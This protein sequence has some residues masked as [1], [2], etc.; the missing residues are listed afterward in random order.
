MPVQSVNGACKSMGIHSTA[1]CGIS[2]KIGIL[3][4]ALLASTALVAA[5]LPASAQDATWLASPGSGD[6]A[7]AA[8]WS[9]GT[10]PSGTASFGNSSITALSFSTTITTVGGWT[11][12]S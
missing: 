4:A 11:F 5:G 12:N 6:Y 10:V 1:A 7:T 3:R 9:T 2:S 8:N